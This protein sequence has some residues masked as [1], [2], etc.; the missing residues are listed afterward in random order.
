MRRGNVRGV[1]RGKSNDY[2]Q[3]HYLFSF[4]EMMQAELVVLKECFGGPGEVETEKKFGTLPWARDEYDNRRKQQGLFPLI[5]LVGTCYGG[6]VSKTIPRKQWAKL[7]TKFPEKFVN[8]PNLFLSQSLLGRSL[9]IFPLEWWYMNFDKRDIY[10][11]CTE[12]M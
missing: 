2:Y 1:A 12:E 11:I 3:E 9:Y 6:K 7:L 10:F 5:D 8:V 4:E